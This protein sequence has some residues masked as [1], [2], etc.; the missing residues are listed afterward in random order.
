MLLYLIGGLALIRILIWFL[1]RESRQ[2]PIPQERFSLP[3][4]ADTET[5]VR[6]YVPPYTTQETNGFYTYRDHENNLMRLLDRNQNNFL[7]RDFRSI[8]YLPHANAFICRQTGVCVVYE[9]DLDKVTET[10]FNNIKIDKYG[11]KL[12]NA[13]GGLYGILN[14]AYKPVTELLCY[15]SVMKGV[16]KNV[17]RYFKDSQYHLVNTQGIKILENLSGAAPCAIDYKLLVRF[18]DKSFALIHLDG[19]LYKRLPFAFVHINEHYIESYVTDAPRYY[20]AGLETN[21]RFPDTEERRLAYTLLNG[22]GDAMF[23]PCYDFLHQRDSN[24][25]DIFMAG[26]G[27]MQWW[28]YLLSEPLDTPP[29][30]EGTVHYGIIDA[31]NNPI[32][33]VAYNTILTIG[34]PRAYLVSQ[35][36]TVQVTKTPVQYEDDDTYWDWEMAGG[37]WGVMNAEGK[38]ILPV[39]YTTITHG[40]SETDQTPYFTTVRNTGDAPQYFDADGNLLAAKP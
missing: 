30:L 21:E 11:N 8:E 18:S 40:I 3:A 38:T 24:N 9:A 13:D 36:G 20:V 25:R 1:T 4:S 39:A 17:V 28:D 22:S 19:S 31:H 34:N 14:D 12:Y 7:N 10:P 6:H 5:P 2:K 26:K 15:D 33:P 29:H 16:A 32:L 35:N 27:N 23:E 37:L